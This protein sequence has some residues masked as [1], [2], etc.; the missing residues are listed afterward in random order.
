[1]IVMYLVFISAL[2]ITNDRSKVI[3]FSTYAMQREHK[4]IKMWVIW[5]LT[6]I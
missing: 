6:R 2:Y 5:L 3:N 1:M 4:C